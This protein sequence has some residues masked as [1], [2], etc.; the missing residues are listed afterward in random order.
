M[1]MEWCNVQFETVEEPV[2]PK[3]E[4]MRIL[5]RLMWSDHFERF[6]AQK[7]TTAKR[8]GLEG[9]DSLIPGLKAMVDVAADAGVQSIVL[10]MPHRGRYVSWLICCM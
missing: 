6:C 7:H 9:C 10:G 3:D 4:K 5:D 2:F 1:G 8:F